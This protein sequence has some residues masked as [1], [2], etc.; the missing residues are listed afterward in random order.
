MKAYTGAGDSGKTSL[1]SGERIAKNE[2]RIEA[3]GNVD[4]LNAVIG[5]MAASLPRHSDATQLRMQLNSIQ[6]D[7][8]QVGAVLATTPDS[9]SINHLR[10]LTFEHS[11]WLEKRIDAMDDRLETLNAFILPGGHPSAAWSHMARTVC[12]RTER[13]VVKLFTSEQLMVTGYQEILVYLNRLSDYFFVL[14]RYCNHLAGIED[15][16]WRG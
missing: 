10:P 13:R 9:P 1:F 7:L 4:E 11:R 14:A 15:E 2:D 6:S 8:F 5:S 12:R 3:Y 16:I